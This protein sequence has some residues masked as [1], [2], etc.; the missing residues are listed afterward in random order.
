[1]ANPKSNDSNKNQNSSS[2]PRAS[3]GKKRSRGAKRSGGK[4]RKDARKTF[5]DFGVSEKT[6]RALADV[7]IKYPTDIQE[8]SLPTLIKGENIMGQAQTGSG[9][10]L[11]FAVP[12]VERLNYDKMEALVLVPTRELCKQVASVFREAGKNHGVKVVEVYGGVSI[13]NQIRKIRHGQN[14]IVAT[15][16]RLIDLFKRGVISFKEIRFIVLDEADRMLDM[17]FFPDIEYILHN[18]GSDREHIQLMLFSATLLDE[19]KKL[20]HQFTHK[21]V[22]E[23]DVSE[24]NLTV[25]ATD[26]Y[27]YLINRYPEK[28]H[29]LVNL[30]RYQKM[31]HVLIFTNTKRAADKLERRLSKEGRLR[32]KGGKQKYRVAGLHGDMGQG[33]REKVIKQ[34]KH[35]Q[36]NLLIATD[37]A[38]RGLDI[39]DVSHVINFDVPK[40][41][42]DYVHRIGRTSRMSKVG[43]AI[44]LCLEDEFQYLCRIEGFI[45][46]DIRRKKLPSVRRG[47]YNHHRGLKKK[48]REFNRRGEQSSQKRNPFF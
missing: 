45:D 25:D 31:K 34:F 23:V 1:M 24:D 32:E 33:S 3:H 43:T 16:G 17:G 22:K 21:P 7:K 41:E 8:A 35:H 20:V 19:I 12:I 26:Q 39:P 42:E 40:Y 44:T 28:Y 37:V 6:V 14:V 9:K 29:V 47:G 11:A 48:R 4:P 30:L 5:A 27:Y 46:K 38:S 10:T 15:P 2:Q 36:V 13:D 18:A